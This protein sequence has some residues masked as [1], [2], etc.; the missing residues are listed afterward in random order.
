VGGY[1]DHHNAAPGVISGRAAVAPGSWPLVTGDPDQSF[2]PVAVAGDYALREGKVVPD[3][4]VVTNQ[5]ET[6]AIPIC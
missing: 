3:G 4:A 6:D 5:D 2:P 1:D